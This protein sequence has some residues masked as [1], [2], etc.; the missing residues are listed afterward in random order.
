M[1]NSTEPTESTVTIKWVFVIAI[2][3]GIFGFFFTSV[4]SQENRITKIET[5]FEAISKDIAEIKDGVSE[6]RKSQI[7]QYKG[8]R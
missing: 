2:I 3:I 7:E 1:A 6:L 4:L 5:R 8:N